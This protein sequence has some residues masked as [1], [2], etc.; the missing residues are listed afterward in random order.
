MCPRVC[1][2]C[3]N[4]QGG[5]PVG[6]PRTSRVVGVPA[7]TSNKCEMRKRGGGGVCA[8]AE[9][10]RGPGEAAPE[11]QAD[12]LATELSGKPQLLEATHIPGLLAPSFI[13]TVKHFKLGLCLHLLYSH[14][15]SLTSTL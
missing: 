3:V 9:C 5:V 6:G 13:F 12:S 10:G 2:A 7:G 15:G 11:L 1:P 14:F 4:E 8:Q